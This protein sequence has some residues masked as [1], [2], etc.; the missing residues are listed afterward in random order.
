MA[1]EFYRIR[2]KSAD[3]LEIDI[4]GDIGGIN[5]DWVNLEITSENTK[6]SVKRLL[7]EIANSAT[8]KII[9][10]INSLGGDVN[11]GISIHDILAEH[12]AKVTTVVNGMTASAATIIAQ[13]GDTR[14]M[15]SNALYLVHPASLPVWGNRFDLKTA[16]SDLEKVDRTIAAIYAKRS[17]KSPEEV[18]ELMSRFDGRGEWLTADEALEYGL[19]DEIVEPMK[20]VAS[21]DPKILAAYRYPEVPINKIDNMKT[22]KKTV[23]SWFEEFMAKISPKNENTP[24]PNEPPVTP[25]PGGD[26]VT[27]EEPE[28]PEVGNPEPPVGDPEPPENAIVIRD[29]EEVRAVL[30]E[31]TTQI[32]ERDRT[33]EN[34]QNEV[35]RLKGTPTMTKE[36]EDPFLDKANLRTN[37]E[38]HDANAQ[39]LRG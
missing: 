31:L 36:R 19:I 13:A 3:T 1:M 10:N 12:K 28:E 22:D 35:A 38:A 14:K 11:H 5:I 16:L 2:N 34:L 6:E 23:F 33:I 25:D 32:E 17:G 8:S 9:V 24:E 30:D 39:A 4:E 21:Y 27:P 20:A 37:E 18:D 7:K 15:S 29:H 26:G